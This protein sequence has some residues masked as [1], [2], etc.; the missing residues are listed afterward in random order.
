MSSARRR[1]RRKADGGAQFSSIIVAAFLTD[2]RCKS[3]YLPELMRRSSC[4]VASITRAMSTTASRRSS[5]FFTGATTAASAGARATEP[6]SNDAA[7]AAEETD[8]AARKRARRSNTALLCS[9]DNA[10]APTPRAGGAEPPE[11]A[12]A[13]RTNSMAAFENFFERAC[14]ERGRNDRRHRWATG[15][16]PRG[17]GCGGAAGWPRRRLRPP[18]LP[19]TATTHA[20]SARASPGRAS[21][22]APWR[23]L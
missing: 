13:A 8:D 16:Q 10:V 6:A 12:H 7:N 19:H 9:L 18:R 17:R 23:Q 1:A 15:A 14:K 22:R 4:S 5:S 11:S 21:G 3:L 2:L 20:L